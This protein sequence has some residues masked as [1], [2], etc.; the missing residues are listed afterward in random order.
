MQPIALSFLIASVFRPCEMSFVIVLQN[1]CC[2]VKVVRVWS[3]RHR[4]IVDE[5]RCTGLKY[6]FCRAKNRWRCCC[7]CWERSGK[8]HSLLRHLL[9][10]HGSGRVVLLAVR[11]E[12]TG[13]VPLVGRLDI[14][15]DH[16]ALSFQ[17][18]RGS[19][20]G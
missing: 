12:S 19:L 14:D 7:F 16:V 13:A 8:I 4:E 9:E 17:R 11:T 2:P 1:V 20:R 10:A 15:C 5:P 18:C 3:K 6:F